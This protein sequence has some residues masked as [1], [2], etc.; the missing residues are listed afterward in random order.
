M[1][2]YSLLLLLLC[3]GVCQ[4]PSAGADTA[5]Q[6]RKAIQT[7]YDREDA[8]AAHRNIN[9]ILSNYAPDYQDREPNGLKVGLAD[10]RQS[11]VVMFQNA[12]AVTAKTTIQNFTLQG[13][14]AIVTT[15]EYAMLTVAS[16]A[17]HGQLHKIVLNSTDEDTW[18]K[19]GNRWLKVSTRTLRQSEM[20]DGKPL[21][22]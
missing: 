7:A 9:G 3:L 20:I 8:A 16:K 22:R 12:R 13:S 18:A 6:A 19:R 5:A 17:E 4:A 21:G 14:K 15:K 10:V 1:H 2:R 11:L